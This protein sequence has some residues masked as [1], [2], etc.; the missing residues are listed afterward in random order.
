MD[1]GSL[2]GEDPLEGEGLCEGH[3]QGEGPLTGEEGPVL[4]RYGAFVLL[5]FVILAVFFI[6]ISPSWF[7]AVELPEDSATA[8]PG[9]TSAGRFIMSGRID[10]NTADAEGLSL[11]PGIGRG[12][13]A[14]IIKQRAALGGFSSI[15]EL[16]GVEGIGERRL[17]A[18]KRSLRAG[19]GN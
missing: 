18:I 1:E 10:I 17:A 8:L 13:A 5:F 9:L 19:P 3:F 14:K 15:D 12:I 6:K 16:R 7:S 11:L 2:T 4:Y